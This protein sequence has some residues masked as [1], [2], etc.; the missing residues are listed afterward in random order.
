[1]HERTLVLGRGS[2]DRLFCAGQR[3]CRI[4]PAVRQIELWLLAPRAALS[5]VER[6]QLGL[7]T[8]RQGRWPMLSRA[9][10]LPEPALQSLLGDALVAVL[11][12]DAVGLATF[13][14]AAS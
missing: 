12:A 8:P 2:T 1:M 11:L 7:I 4:G 6:R 13:P 10:R 5:Y 3:T 14:A 9:A